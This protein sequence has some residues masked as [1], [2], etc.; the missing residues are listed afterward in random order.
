MTEVLIHIGAG[1]RWSDG[2]RTWY[3]SCRVCDAWP[4]AVTE[5]HPEALEFACD[6]IALYHHPEA[7]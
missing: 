5:T 3:V 4:I 1:R 2:A 7:P 6:H